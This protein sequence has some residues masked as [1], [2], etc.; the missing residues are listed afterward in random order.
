LGIITG[1]R[2]VTTMYRCG[3]SRAAAG[4]VALARNAGAELHAIRQSAIR[5]ARY[6]IADHPQR[7]SQPQRTK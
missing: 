6:L 7:L 1:L 5:P 3:D 2:T 4:S